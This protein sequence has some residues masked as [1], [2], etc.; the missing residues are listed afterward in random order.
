M[1]SFVLK[2]GT[3]KEFDCMEV[4]GIIN[5]TPDSFFAGSR[6]AGKDEAI[7]RAETL[8]SEG[9]TFIDIGGES[10]RPGAAKVEISEEI[11]RVCPVIKELKERHPEIILSVDTYNSETA[12]AA[13]EVGVDI[14]NDISGLTFDDNMA[15]VC[16]EGNVPVIIMHT[17]GRP[18]VM[19]NAPH[20]EDVVRE[21]HEYLEKQ[22]NYGINK[23]IAKDKIIIDLGIGFGKTYDHN[24]ELLRNIEK[25]DDLKCPHLLAV[26][27]KT[28]IG[29]LLGEEDPA[30]RLFGTV[31]VTLYGQSKGLEIVRV[32]DVKANY[33]GIKMMN[34]LT[35]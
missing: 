33:Q 11:K 24:M 6:T 12:K 17:G 27:R 23:G 34:E 32:H 5:V 7:E 18:D 2:D 26:S 14:I 25:F 4:M 13:I 20:Y 15:N 22:I 35:K 1:R 19:Q 29:K 21:V 10:T 31:A 3:K 28:F 9:A 16:A 8:I 30:D